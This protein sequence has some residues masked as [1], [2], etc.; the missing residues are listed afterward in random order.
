MKKL[1]ACIA[2]SAITTM[3]LSA[4]YMLVLTDK[5]GNQTQECIKSYSFSNNLESL[6][7]KNGVG[8][9]DIYSKDETM[10][11]K[12][13]V[14]GKPIYRRVQIL[15]GFTEEGAFNDW[16]LIKFDFDTSEI[17]KLVSGEIDFNGAHEHYTHHEG[18]SSS[19]FRYS[20]IKTGL[21]YVSKKGYVNSNTVATVIIEY[22]KTTDAADS[23]SNTF[24]SYLHY[25]P[26]SSD[27]EEVITKDMKNLGVQFLEGYTYDSSTSSCIKN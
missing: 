10:T 1:L 14:D 2:F 4:D 8:L 5:D 19:Q 15:T 3:S 24:K 25:V 11:N 23:S 26:S 9:K 13:W 7:R 20:I 21:S 6:A 18:S 16:R 27:T 17:E 22:T 12:V